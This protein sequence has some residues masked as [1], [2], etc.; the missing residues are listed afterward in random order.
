MSKVE[1]KEVL[2]VAMVLKDIFVSPVL[3]MLCKNSRKEPCNQGRICDN[4]VHEICVPEEILMKKY[5][6][7]SFCCPSCVNDYIK[8]VMFS[9]F[10]NF[11]TNLYIF[12]ER[13][14]QGKTDWNKR[15]VSS[16]K[17]FADF[18]YKGELQGVF[19]PVSLVF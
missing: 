12:R 17:N 9:I 8:Y 16:V 6:M 3:C 13:D 19:G 10:S 11:K 1:G 15:I 2:M 7:S 18:I 4:Y 14:R 5:K